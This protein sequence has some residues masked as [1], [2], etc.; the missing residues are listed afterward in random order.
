MDC[1]VL[2]G[3]EGHVVLRMKSRVGMRMCAATQFVRQRC[4]WLWG[5]VLQLLL[6]LQV[7]A[8]TT[9]K[10]CTLFAD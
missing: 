1:K 8:F 7:A 10:V 6:L 4:W 3:E 9:C 2:R 5:T